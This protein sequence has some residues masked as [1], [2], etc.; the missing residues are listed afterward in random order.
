MSRSATGGEKAVK[1]AKAA[2]VVP[3]CIEVRG[4]RE[5]NLKNIDVTIPRDSLTV[6][7]GVS[8][9]GKSTLA[10]D[11][12]FAEGRRRYMES[13]STYARQFLGRMSKPDCD[14]IEGL[15][16]AIAIEQRGL[17]TNPR[18]TVGTVTEILDYLRLLFAR[19]GEVR[20]Y[21]CG[22]RMVARS[23]QEVAEETLD[24]AEGTRFSVLAPLLI[25]KAGDVGA[26]AR[27]MLKQGFTRITVDG[28]MH[29][30]ADLVGDAA[31]LARFEKE[32]EKPRNV[33]L[34]VDRLVLRDG[35]SSR[36]TEAIELAM[37]IAGG[38][39]KIAPLEGD[40]RIYTEKLVCV[41]CGIVYPEIEPA[42]FSFNSPH[43]ACAA[44]SGL[45]M[46][47]QLDATTFVP[48]PSLSVSGGALAPLGDSGK[49][50]ER[51][52]AEAF[53]ASMGFSRS[54][55]FR[56]LPEVVRTALIEGSQA[57]ARDELMALAKDGET[58]PAYEGLLPML[59]R[60]AAAAIPAELMPFCT[61][62]PCATCE[63][64]RLRVEARHVFV[65]GDGAETNLPKLTR[66]SLDALLAQLKGLELSG[67]RGTIAAPIVREIV[68]RLTF[69]A[70][71]GVG[72][73]SLDR[74][75]GTLSGGEA[76]RIRLAT[77]IG[78]ALSGVLYILDEPSIGLHARDHRRLL[79]HLRRLRDLGNTVVVV[80]HDAD[81]IGEADY[82]IDM[83]P[84]AGVHG[85]NVV[86]TG[87]VAEVRANAASLTGQ[88]L[89]GVKAIAVPKRRRARG[90]KAIVIR[91]AHGNNLRHVDVEIPLGMLVCVTGV[92]GSGKSTLINDT[93]YPAL[94]GHGHVSR[95]IAPH[96]G[97]EGRDFVER[98][99]AVDQSPIGK[100]PRANPATYTGVYAE[101]RKLFAQVQESRVRGWN[102][103]R[104]SFNAK[105]GRCEVCEG[106]GLTRV[107]MHF[108]PDLYVRCEACNGTRFNRETLSVRYRGLNIAEMLELTVGDAARLLE[109]VPR[110]RRPLEA[111]NRVGLDYIRLGQ[112]A[113]TL[114]GGESQRVK[115]ARELARPASE[116]TLYLF[117]EPT[118]GLHFDDVAR[119]VDVFGQLIAAG[120]SVLVI[121][122]NL[123]VVKCAD[124]VIDLGPEGGEGGGEVIACGT[125][126]EVARVARSHTGAALK[127]VLR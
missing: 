36:L 84:G 61:P 103:A 33:D 34:F 87:T 48:D 113:S 127:K 58:T 10:F 71:V 100:T 97:I 4:A 1:P 108:L 46:L 125:P 105:G 112:A 85:G 25:D 13:L 86:A 45:G 22:T 40:D 65:G 121:E 51:E 17:T 82:L 44:C 24:L 114:S 124:W 52:R 18:S 68:S 91:D 74:R 77:Q 72:Y 12:L 27:E 109:R 83:G 47:P 38:V 106:Q 60:R 55:P 110:A 19:I 14:S 21:A 120:H 64:D 8:G 26:L 62:H 41:R 56:D 31:L 15:S 2:R 3:R 67:T 90:K 123:D 119:L 99:I 35:I 9:S 117:D 111:L 16:P 37:K 80:E 102:A 49:S 28:E 6:V 54:V 75:A 70:G 7:T 122:H 95:I 98:V 79:D 92:S 88:Y 42:L 11:T 30:L 94:R 101:I 32:G 5:H 57:V 81:T 89:A 29:D 116:H 93:L 23:A 107:E 78:S 66:V 69:L 50:P 118:T 59:Q 96:G 104:F 20:C 39:V 63:G 115:L 53:L 76:Q 73:L 43:G 126:E